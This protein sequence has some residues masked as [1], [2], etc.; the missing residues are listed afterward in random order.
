LDFD[1]DLSGT[2]PAVDSQIEMARS[3]DGSV[4]VGRRVHGWLFKV[5]FG[6]QSSG[7]RRRQDKG[8]TRIA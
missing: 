5:E 6:D 4:E 3:D 2:V 8:I 1:G 7:G